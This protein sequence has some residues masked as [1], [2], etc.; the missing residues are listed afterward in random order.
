MRRGFADQA[1]LAGRQ[2]PL[3]LREPGSDPRPNRA[4]F[5]GRPEPLEGPRTKTDPG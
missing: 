4:R 2:P 3:R 1:A 5:V